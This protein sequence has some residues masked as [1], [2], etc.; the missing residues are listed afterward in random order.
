MVKMTIFEAK[1]IFQEITILPT[2]S[3]NKP[4]IRTQ[5]VKLGL[6]TVFGDIKK[7]SIIGGGILQ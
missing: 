5:E 2:K 1:N 7:F 3:K 4:Q 6:E